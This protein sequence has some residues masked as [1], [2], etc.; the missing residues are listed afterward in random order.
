MRIW[1]GGGDGGGV[2][3]FQS[4][5][6][7]VLG[8]SSGSVGVSDAGLSGVEPPPG[9]FGLAVAP[10]AKGT[11]VGATGATGEPVAEVGASVAPASSA[12][13]TYSLGRPKGMWKQMMRGARLNVWWGEAE[14]G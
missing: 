2:R 1:L 9:V 7:S 4:F 3:I 5:G 6:A 11:A 8:R 13:D 10:G 14:G 12:H